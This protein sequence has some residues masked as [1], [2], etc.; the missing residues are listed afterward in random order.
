MVEWCFCIS[1]MI[2]TW[3]CTHPIYPATIYHGSV[4]R[5]N[6]FI[7]SDIIRIHSSPFPVQSMCGVMHSCGA[8]SSMHVCGAFAV[9]LRRIYG[10]FA[11]HLRCICGAFAVHL[12]CIC[13][14]FE[15]HLRCIYCAF[16]LQAAVQL[17]SVALWQLLQSSMIQCGSFVADFLIN[18]CCIPSGPYDFMQSPQE[19]QVS[20]LSDNNLLSY[21]PKTY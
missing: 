9:H 21:C 16:V 12:R 19:G 2:V 17:R 7:R 10:A 14:A 1:I 13:G 3:L 18:T 20:R 15:V 8:F 4:L 11:V 5:M 6:S